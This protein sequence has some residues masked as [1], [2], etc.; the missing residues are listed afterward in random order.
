[1]DAT[2][3][4]WWVTTDFESTDAPTPGNSEWWETFLEKHESEEEAFLGFLSARGVSHRDT[5][6]QLE[7]LYTEWQAPRT[8]AESREAAEDWIEDNL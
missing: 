3:D 5:P 6:A 7:T 4:E 8:S 1:M 2:N